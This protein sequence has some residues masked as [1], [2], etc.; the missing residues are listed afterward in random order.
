MSERGIRLRN[1]RECT[2]L[3]DGPECNVLEALT[4]NHEH[5]NHMC[6]KRDNLRVVLAVEGS[7]CLLETKQPTPHAMSLA[8]K[9][10]LTTMA[11]ADQKL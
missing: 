7:P 3:L 10:V 8:T 4:R 1:W 5:C 6:S 11:M 9:H 2:K